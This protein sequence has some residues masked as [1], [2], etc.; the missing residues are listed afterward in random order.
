M[1]AWLNTLVAS[2]KTGTVPTLTL[3]GRFNNSTTTSFYQNICVY[4]LIFR[5]IFK[6]FSPELL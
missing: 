2:K 4:E 6:T 1:I 3:M 5:R